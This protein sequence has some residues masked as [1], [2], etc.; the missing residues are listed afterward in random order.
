MP[1]S[2]DETAVNMIFVDAGFPLHRAGDARAAF[3][4]C[5][6][7]QGD[8]PHASVIRQARGPRRFRRSRRRVKSR[9]DPAAGSTA[10]RR[11]AWGCGRRGGPGARPRPR[12]CIAA[13]MRRGS[14]DLEIAVLTSTASQPSSIARAASEAVPMPASSTTGTGLRAQISSIAA[15]LAMPRARA[16]QRAQRHHRG[17]ADIGELLAGD[18]IVVAIGQHDKAL[19]HQFVGGM[20][21]LLDIGVERLAVADQFE[22]DP[23]GLQRLARQFGGQ[24][25][26]ARGDAAGGVGQQPAARRPADRRGCRHSRRG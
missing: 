14:C 23:V 4:R 16:D 2:P 18:R 6:P 7:V 3:R 1:L 26:V 10:R 25:R 13:A 19:A 20:H 21:E 12:P 22:L 15:G 5:P 17:A 9:R 11:C 8:R 24:D